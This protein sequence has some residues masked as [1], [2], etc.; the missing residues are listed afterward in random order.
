MRVEKI[1]KRLRLEFVLIWV[2]AAVLAICY[3]TALFSEGACVGDATASYILESAAVL[4]TLAA[5]PVSL[6]ISGHFLY[7]RIEGKSEEQAAL[8]LLRWSEVQIFLLMIV[9]LIDLSVYYSTMDSLGL[10]CSAVGLIAS[11]FCFPT[12][13][14]L[15]HYLANLKERKL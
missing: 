3:E 9:V 2:L 5:V 10:L 12:K 11:V 8:I 14:R 1:V 4:L 6:K 13:T 15:E 7:R